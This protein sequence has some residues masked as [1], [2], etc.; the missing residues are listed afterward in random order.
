MTQNKRFRLSQNHKSA[1]SSNR[2]STGL[3]QRKRSK[4]ERVNIA[5]RLPIQQK[6]PFIILHQLAF[7]KRLR[8]IT[9]PLPGTHQLA[10]ASLGACDRRRRHTRRAERAGRKMANAG[11]R[12]NCLGLSAGWVETSWL[13]GGSAVEAVDI[14]LIL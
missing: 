8:V 4:H 6:S 5:L 1:T 12:G 11:R 2:R 14:I 3:G 7:K 9:S 13:V 10:V